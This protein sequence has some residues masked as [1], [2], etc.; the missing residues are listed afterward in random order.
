MARHSRSLL[1]SGV[2][3]VI[4]DHRH[5][6]D[7]RLEAR[8]LDHP[9]LLD[10][11]HPHQQHFIKQQQQQQPSLLSP[12]PKSC[13]RCL[14]GHLGFLSRWDGRILINLRD[15]EGCPRKQRTPPDLDHPGPAPSTTCTF[16]PASHLCSSSSLRSSSSSPLRK[17]RPST[18]TRCRPL[19]KPKVSPTRATCTSHSEVVYT[20]HGLD[21]PWRRYWRR[22]RRAILDPPVG[23]PTQDAAKSTSIEKKREELSTITTPTVTTTEST[24]EC[25]PCNSYLECT[26]LLF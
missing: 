3:L 6:P 21:R 1:E 11:E 5:V 24:E 14:L 20:L 12:A 17:L 25:M 9:H 2:D 18:S 10:P 16:T 7:H 8:R 23:T 13:R 22:R 19:A 15:R 26:A 4:P